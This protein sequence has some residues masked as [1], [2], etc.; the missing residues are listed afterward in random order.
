[1]RTHKQFSDPMPESLSP[2][3]LPSRGTGWRGR[4]PVYAAVLRVSSSLGGKDLRDD[5]VV[6]FSVGI[7]ICAVCCVPWS[8]S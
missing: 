2:A 7:S 5:H 4:G 3:S 8:H 1:M 6:L